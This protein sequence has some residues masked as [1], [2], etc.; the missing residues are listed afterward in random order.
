MRAQKARAI[1]V[2]QVRWRIR[3]PHLG[4]PSDFAKIA[5]HSDPVRKGSH[6]DE[7][8]GRAGK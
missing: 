2:N 6:I 1:E 4:F 5:A 8:R 3:Y 7:P